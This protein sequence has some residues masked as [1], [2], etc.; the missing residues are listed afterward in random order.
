MMMMK[1]F[2]AAAGIMAAVGAAYMLSQTVCNVTLT[3]QRSTPNPNP[4]KEKTEDASETLQDAREGAEESGGTSDLEEPEPPSEVKSESES[5]T[6]GDNLT[7]K[8]LAEEFSLSVG[9]V[10][11]TIRKF[12]IAPKGSVE[13]NGGKAILYDKN[14]FAEARRRMGK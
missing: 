2:L 10:N 3:V 5:G 1:K 4:D 14:E 9:V 8:Q 13:I 7:V 11:Y 12:K 6:S